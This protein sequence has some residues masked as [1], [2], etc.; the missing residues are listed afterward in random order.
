MSLADQTCVPCKGGVPPMDSARA[1]EL[2]RELDAGWAVNAEGH[3]ERI[4]LL[5][6]GRIDVADARG[7]L[8]QRGRC[9]G[10]NAGQPEIREPP[11]RNH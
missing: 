8:S 7:A 10:E 11:K 5:A 3:L 9:A 1:Q 2:L 4:T 6:P